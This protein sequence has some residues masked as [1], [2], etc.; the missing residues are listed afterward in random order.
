[1]TASGQTYTVWE[2]YIKY[3]CKKEV[4]KYSQD[5]GVECGVSYDSSVCV[6]QITS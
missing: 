3:E 6:L 4:L 5:Q 2:M 1:M